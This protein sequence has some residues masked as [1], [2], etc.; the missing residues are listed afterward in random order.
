MNTEIS[1]SYNFHVLRNAILLLIFFQLLKNAKTVLS[2]QPYKNRVVGWIWPT[3]DSLSTPV[4][5]YEHIT[6]HL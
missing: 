3:G 5:D 2:L 4:L 1:M 6:K